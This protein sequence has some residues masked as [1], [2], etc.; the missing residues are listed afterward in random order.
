M[1]RLRPVSHIMER[2]RFLVS[3]LLKSIEVIELGKTWKLSDRIH[4]AADAQ[5]GAKGIG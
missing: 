5:K 1:L 4:A 2:E 3:Q